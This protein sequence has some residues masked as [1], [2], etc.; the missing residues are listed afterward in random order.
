MYQERGASLRLLYQIKLGLDKHF[1]DSKLSVTGL[2]QRTVDKKV[3]HVAE[4]A[5][6]LPAIKGEYGIEGSTI[7]P[8]KFLSHVEEKLLKFELAHAELKER[9][10]KG[11]EQERNMLSSIQ[12]DKRKEAIRKLKENKEFMKDWESK[13]KES[14]KQ[15][16]EKRAYE[17]KRA[18]E[19]EDR[20][21]SIYKNKLDKE[22]SFNNNDM[23]KGIDNFH[24]NMQKL[25]IE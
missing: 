1:G 16:Q 15:N 21:V 18:L 10:R 4:L 7:A 13:G 19:F 24:E 22:L 25:G 14:W 2:N 23:V 9:A 12:Q 20:E 3:K 5:T 11:D 17:I 8:S 6:K